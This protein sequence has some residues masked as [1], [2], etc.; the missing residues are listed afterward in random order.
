MWPLKSQHTTESVI[1]QEFLDE[2]Y[3]EENFR[4]KLKESR[5]AHKRRIKGDHKR[6][7]KRK[8]KERNHKRKRNQKDKVS[9]LQILSMVSEVFS[10]GGQGQGKSN[11]WLVKMEDLA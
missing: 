8:R 7:R 9:S 2:Y 11:Q 4:V 3:S 6:K 10:N 5:K 1:L